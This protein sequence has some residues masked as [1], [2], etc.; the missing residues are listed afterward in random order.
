MKKG[1]TYLL[2][3]SMLALAGCGANEAAND[4]KEPSS[5]EIAEKQDATISIT[6]FAD[7]TITF[8]EVPENIISVGNG[9]LDIIYALG[10]ELVGRATTYN[11]EINKQLADVEQVGNTHEFDLEKIAS[12]QPDV[13]LA[14]NPLNLKDIA[15]IEGIGSQIILTHANSV[16]DIQDQ[17]TLFGDMIQKQDKATELV[18]DIEQKVA[19]IEA[20][21]TDAKTRVLLI[22]GAPGTYMAALP[23]SLSGNL[24]E[25]AG[26]ENI[27]S[28]YPAIEK[29]PQYAQLNTERI[30]E[31]NPEYIFLMTHADPNAVKEGF[32]KEMAQNPAWNSINAVK[33]ERIEILPADLFGDNPGTKVVDALDY[34]HTLLKSAQ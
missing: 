20:K 8:D 2:M 25:L 28:D 12:L 26:G 30:V 34:M 29:Y 6:D 24:L 22:Y 9:E 23:N 4:E 3:A 17:I 5:A 19:D 33:N 11:E 14:N 31:A 18:A 10:G 21:A 15:S 16:S 1:F 32:I 7:R 13:V 27:A